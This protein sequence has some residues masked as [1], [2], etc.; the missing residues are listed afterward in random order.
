MPQIVGLVQALKWNNLA[1]STA[2]FVGPR[3]DATT[4]VFY[5]TY[6]L[7]DGSAQ[8]GVKRTMIFA[9]ER[10]LEARL[11]VKFTYIPNSAELLQIQ[12][13]P[14]LA[15]YDDIS[16]TT[17]N[18]T[19]GGGRSS[20]GLTLALAGDETAL[21]A[22]SL[23]AGV[24]KSEMSGRWTH[25][26]GS[27][28]R[29]TCI[30]ADP[31]NPFHLAVGERNGDAVNMNLNTSGLWESFDAGQ[32]WT[33]SCNPLTV[34]GC[35]SQAVPAVVF[36]QASTLF[37]GTTCGIGRKTL[38]DAD[39]D[40]SKSPP[41]IG[42]VTALAVSETKVWARTPN[43]LL[44]SA[45][46]G[47]T[48]TIIPIPSNLAGQ[49]IS[50]NSRG[51]LFSLA[52]FDA[53]AFLVYKPSPDT[54]G[55]KDTVLIYDV[56]NNSWRTQVLD[57]GDGTGLG[58][59]R[60]VKSYVLS[61]AGLQPGIGGELQL[62]YGAG[63]E[64]LQAVGLNVDG[65]LQWDTSVQTNWGGPYAH[66][67]DNIHSDIWDFHIGPSYC[68]PQQA[69]AL[70]AC[71]GGVFR[72]VP[73]AVLPKNFQGHIN[74]MTWVMC[75]DGLSTHHVHTL[76]T[77]PVPL[78]T[79]RLAYATADND[80]W[81]A[82]CFPDWRHKDALGDANWSAGDAG[83]PNIALIVRRPAGYAMLT[84]FDLAPPQGANFAEWQRITLNN[85]ETYNGPLF[86]QFIQTLKNESP[87]FPLLD[88]VM[89]ANLPLKYSDASNNLVPVPGLLGRANPGGNP[90]LI[91]AKQ[92]AANPDQNYSHF[93]N[94]QIEAN[95]LPMGTRGFW[96]SGGHANPVYYLSAP[97]GQGLTLY[98]RQA[99]GA[100]WLPLI[101]GM[102][103]GSTYG[104]AF[105]NPFNPTRIFVLTGTGVK[106]SKDGGASFQDQPNLT[107][108][109]TGAGKFPITGTFTA[110]GVGVV[111][112]SQAFPLGTLSHMAFNR[113]N[114][115]EIVAASPF[116]GVFYSGD[117]GASWTDLAKYLP[118]PR[119]SVSAVG[120]DCQAIYVA[121]EGRSVVRLLGYRNTI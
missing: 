23:N 82:A 76:T 20:A 108:L 34:Q 105:I 7:L 91:R 98:K 92:F 46:G 15:S 32:T 8:R 35:T 114:P 11:P 19:T 10:A 120:I 54:V 49:G 65:T 3:R 89:L 119:T 109:L 93:Q 22:V 66:P 99:A 40:F 50:F 121:T 37:I 51:D 56:G 38:A 58:G 64:V 75:V 69:S 87:S 77:L 103:D 29:A 43:K 62:F 27:P 71:D 100:G 25:L 42:S 44:V 30:A 113:G 1:S 17:P 52:A 95:D 118:T 115:L 84:S 80:G 102:L 53:L 24:W 73:P 72:A 85:D 111:H 110:N 83:N 96:V 67:P 57:A 90:V 6:G 107:A 112:A 14:A 4:N 28:E 79:A 16:P 5:I 94:W 106:A 9:L 74:Q 18:L 47:L 31:N 59:R 48:W 12:L 36:T 63:Q 55:N 86:L 33:Y 41:N 81:Y 21:Y 117:D 60:F 88:A 78:A 61:C 13:R 104:P 101:G 70:I 97:G 2:I 68:P 45:D 39:F 116:T 26:S